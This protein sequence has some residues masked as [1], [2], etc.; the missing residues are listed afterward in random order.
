MEFAAFFA[1][2]FAGHT[3][4]DHWV[5]SSHQAVCKGGAGWPARRACAAHVASLQATKLVLVGVAWLALDLD[6]NAWGVALALVVDGASHY[7]A[8][9]RTTLQKLAK[10]V[11]KEGF[12][13]QG[14][15]LVN[16]KGET[17]PHVGTGRYQLDQSWHILWLVLATDLAVFLSI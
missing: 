11:G 17:A 1:A 4:G 13:D 2:M 6:L 15:D 16:A 7:W 10:A 3:V 9:R 12:Y 14:T 8:D 5:Q